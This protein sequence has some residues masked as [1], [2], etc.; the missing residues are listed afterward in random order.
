[1]IKKQKIGI[2]LIVLVITIIVIIIL[3]GSVI[4]SLADNNPVSTANEAKFKTNV[5]QYN[6][7]LGMVISSK[8]LLDNTF[9]P[10]SLNAGL[11][12]GTES[13]I[14]GTIK[15]YITNITPEDGEKFVLQNGKLAYI[16]IETEQIEYVTDI[17]VI[18]PVL[19]Y[20][21]LGV[22]IIATANSTVN[23]QAPS[24][25]N[26]IIPKNFKA[27]NDGTKWPTDWNK[28]LVIEDVNGNQ[29]VWVP[30][31]GIDITYTTDYT[32]YV[33]TFPAGIT[34]ETD[35]IDKYEGFYIGRY[36]AGKEGTILVSKKNTTVWNNITHVNAKAQSQAM[37]T[38]PE[39]KSGL[40]TNAQWSVIKK[41]ITNSGRTLEDKTWGNFKDSQSPANVTGFGLLQKSGFSDY[42]KFNNIYDFAGNTFEFINELRR[43]IIYGVDL[44]LCISY[45][46]GSYSD[47]HSV[48]S[49][50][51][52]SGTNIASTHYRV[53]LSFRVVLYIL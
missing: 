13:N 44:G 10:S 18:N 49:Y 34:N 16:G 5:E 4:L 37:Y 15:E 42:W 32:E 35:Q 26:P 1:M 17:G 6:S 19:E 46:N 38:T 39:V 24:Y 51:V 33:Y 8:Y 40:N 45:G 23:G 31:N 30:V 21:L 20:P 25:N 12:D 7:E 27:I 47:T 43:L 53:D 52:T 11:W 50:Y 9:D 3:A 28:G 48:N 22:N 41:W 2:S 36:E 14:E 29:F